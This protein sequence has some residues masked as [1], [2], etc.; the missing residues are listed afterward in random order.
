MSFAQKISSIYLI[1]II[2]T[3]NIYPTVKLKYISNFTTG[4][5]FFIFHIPIIAQK[6]QLVLQD[7]FRI[8]IFLPYEV[9][10]RK[11]SGARKNLARAP[12]GA[13]CK[14]SRRAK[15][16][17]QYLHPGTKNIDAKYGT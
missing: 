11:T 7:I 14:F 17:P 3:N 6:K 2:C 8:C 4:Y 10:R 1:I 13:Q 16:L 15:F 9:R 5:V 12:A